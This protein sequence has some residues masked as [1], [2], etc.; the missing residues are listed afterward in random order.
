MMFPYSQ[1][2]MRPYIS[3]N[4]FQSGS[5]AMS[6]LGFFHLEKWSNI[7]VQTVHGRGPKVA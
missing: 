5:T 4:R 1:V 6:D 3:R 7:P 2:I